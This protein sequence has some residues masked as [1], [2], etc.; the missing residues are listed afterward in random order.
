MPSTLAFGAGSS[1]GIVFSPPPPIKAVS[2]WTSDIRSVVEHL[3]CMSEAL[4]SALSAAEVKKHLMLVCLHEIW[5]T[6]KC[7]II[8]NMTSKSK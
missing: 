8:R 5:L 3:F 1:L 2:I 6:L 7:L 4:D